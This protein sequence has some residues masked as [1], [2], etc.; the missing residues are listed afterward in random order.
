MSGF[1][2]YLCMYVCMYV[3]TVD[4]MYIHTIIFRSGLQGDGERGTLS[5]LLAA[6]QSPGSAH[7]DAAQAL[8]G[9]GALF[10]IFHIYSMSVSL[11]DMLCCNQ[12]RATHNGMRKAVGKNV[13]DNLQYISTHGV[14]CALFIYVFDVI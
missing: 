10:T 2:M 6:V 3:C 1:C 14:S 8:G 7:G 5:S 4:E 9:Q 11:L 13:N 12:V